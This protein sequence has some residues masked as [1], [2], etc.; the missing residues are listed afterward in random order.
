MAPDGTK[1]HKLVDGEYYGTPSWALA[2]RP[3]QSR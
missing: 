2:G 1:A 3:S